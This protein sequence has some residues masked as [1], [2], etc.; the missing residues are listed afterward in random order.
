[1]NN[2][3]IKVSVHYRDSEKSIVDILKQSLWFYI[4]EE[5]K[6]LCKNC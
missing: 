1:M 4:I 2:S 5:V 3:C 6:R